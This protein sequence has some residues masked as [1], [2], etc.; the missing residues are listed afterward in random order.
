[1]GE[2]LTA[3]ILIILLPITIENVIEIIK[4]N[5][6]LKSAEDCLVSVC[7]ITAKNELGKK[8]IGIKVKKTSKE[9]TKGVKK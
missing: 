3:I 5:K 4:I 6:R 7:L 2:L 1:M 9:S 8:G